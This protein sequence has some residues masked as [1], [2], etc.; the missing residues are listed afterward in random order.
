MPLANVDILHGIVNGSTFISQFTSQEVSPTVQAIILHAAGQVHPQFASV[1]K[2]IPKKRFTTP[3]IKT[4]L[5]L[6]GSSG[7]ADLSGA[8]TDLYFKA[9]ADQGSRGASASSLHHRLRATKAFLVAERLTAAHDGAEAQIQCTIYCSYD[10]TNA[11]LAYTGSV[12]LSGTPASAEHYTLG[13]QYLNGS[14]L[15]GPQNL[16][17]DYRQNILEIGGSGD[18]YNTF[19][20]QLQTT[21]QVSIDVVPSGIWSNG[22]AFDISSGSLYLRK[23]DRTGNV[24]NATAEHIKFSVPDGLACIDRTMGSGMSPNVSTLILNPVAA[25]DTAAALILSSTAVAITT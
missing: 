7:I 22:L 18:M 14:Q 3:Q 20:A 4:I 25:S 17:I 15:D 24:A 13:P 2:V 21:P 11:P 12:A 1:A 5:D 10:G 6:V 19:H 8:N 9:A 16:D 23:K